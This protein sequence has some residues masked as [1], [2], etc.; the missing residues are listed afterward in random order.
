MRAQPLVHTVATVDQTTYA[1]NTF[2][3]I[4][5]RRYSSVRRLLGVTAICLKFINCLLHQTQRRIPSVCEPDTST[6]RT[7][8]NTTQPSLP[9]KISSQDLSH[10]TLL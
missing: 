7:M 1:V 5:A 10:A 9:L 4:D 6:L 8:L 3:T 2:L